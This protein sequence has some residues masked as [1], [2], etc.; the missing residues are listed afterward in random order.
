MN[1]T[2]K[3]YQQDVYLREC[4]SIVQAVITDPEEI[5][6][7]GGIE[8]E[9]SLCLVLDKTVFFP[10][11]GGQPC[12]T[13]YVFN[14][15]LVFYVFEKDGIVYHQ[16]IISPEDLPNRETNGFACELSGRFVKC[17]I[18]WQQRFSNMQRHCGEH[19]L[20]AVFYELYGG[21]NRGFHMGSDYMTIDINLE[22]NP[23]YTKLTDDMML[24]AELEA[25]RMI[26]DNQ[27]V[28]VRYFEKREDA[29]NLPMRKALAVEED[30]ILVCVGDESKP[31]GCVA[32]CGTH[33][34]TTGEV[35]LIKLYKWESYK[36]MTRITFDA[37]QNA[38]AYCRDIS[39]IIK[40]LCKR[41]SSDSGSLIDRIIAQEQKNNDVRQEYY[42]LKKTYLEDQIEE[43]L[44]SIQKLPQDKHVEF[45]GGKAVGKVLV[46]EYPVLK[47]DDLLLLG[48]RL[49]SIQSHLIALISTGENTVVLINGGHFD[50]GRIVKDNAHVWRGKGGGRADNAR[51]MFPSRQDLDCFIEYLKKAY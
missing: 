2:V 50:C 19:I 27:K 23:E 3:L 12:D 28:T 21:V 15:S 44:E 11:G 6:R 22:E 8:K 49:L 42:E 34:A 47:T 38:L 18:N 43:I 14:E 20:S 31:A 41:F 10:E 25:N 40:T 30:I 39:D 45:T 26:W 9:G 36:G 33:P 37:G 16:V 5:K 35:G 24:K 1:N 29:E 32:C 51:V 17:R 48:R 13:G 7:L 46:R 4:E